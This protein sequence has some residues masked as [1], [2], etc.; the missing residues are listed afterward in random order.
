MALAIRSWQHLVPIAGAFSPSLIMNSRKFFS[1]PRLTIC[2]SWPQ[3]CSNF[4]ASALVNFCR[5]GWRVLNARCRAGVRSR[6]ADAVAVAGRA[7]RVTAGR[8]A[9]GVVG[10][11]A[12]LVDRPFEHPPQL[13]GDR[14]P[15]LGDVDVEHCIEVGVEVQG[16]P[17]EL[18]VLVDAAD[19]T[20][21]PHWTNRMAR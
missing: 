15:H 17:G 2:G 19:A 16:C 10:P 4:A 14:H 6:A 5:S 18:G 20:P 13:R 9:A 21:P 11:A 8:F 3:E 12:Q 7:G 1:A